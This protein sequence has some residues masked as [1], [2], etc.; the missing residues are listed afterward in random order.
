MIA[1]FAKITVESPDFEGMFS[2]SADDADTLLIS[3][4]DPGLG[5]IQN[6]IIE[7]VNTMPC[8]DGDNI[9]RIDAIDTSVLD[10]G[11]KIHVVSF[12]FEPAV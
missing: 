4:L 9:V 3:Q 12:Y 8:P 6:S 10:N 7:N 2:V 1:V 5:D 11:G